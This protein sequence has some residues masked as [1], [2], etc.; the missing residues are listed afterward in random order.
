MQLDPAGITVTST[1]PTVSV[2]IPTLNE[3][4]SIKIVIESIPVEV[5]REAEI[6]VV[7]GAPTQPVISPGSSR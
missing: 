7:D 6:L 5:R 1:A 4:M 3:G 2:I